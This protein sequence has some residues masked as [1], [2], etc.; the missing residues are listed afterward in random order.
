MHRLQHAFLAALT[1][2]VA[3]CNAPETADQHTEPNQT[4]TALQQSIVHGESAV[5]DLAV[6]ASWE[7]WVDGVVGTSEHPIGWASEAFWCLPNAEV[8]ALTRTPRAQ[9][10]EFLWA[11]ADQ[12]AQRNE[13]YGLGG[14]TATSEFGLDREA[15][16][17]GH[18]GSIT[19]L[20]RPLEHYQSGL[21]FDRAPVR[22]RYE[23]SEHF[24]ERM[25]G[26]AA[27]EASR[28]VTVF[29]VAGAAQT[30]SSS[31]RY[32]E[33]YPG[34][35]SSSVR[36]FLPRGR[37]SLYEFDRYAEIF[38]IRP[39]ALNV[40]DCESYGARSNR[41]FQ[42]GRWE[43]DQRSSY[44]N[45]D[46]QET[47]EHIFARASMLNARQ[48]DDALSGFSLPMPG[49]NGQRASDFVTVLGASVSGNSTN[50][51]PAFSAVAF[52]VRD[53][54]TGRKLIHIDID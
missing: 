35:E 17:S 37:L 19:T 51:N 11:W 1:L 15:A 36:T 27:V 28:R 8:V 10:L 3:C 13:F 32:N 5:P 26:Y 43:W 21:E 34:W 18:T 4:T 46:R 30:R 39:C 14:T 16:Q 49:Q 24:D 44:L 54:C 41:S 47:T 42:W 38:H 12:L 9:Q 20:A 7:T 23:P 31:Y 33:E 6:P 25:A 40:D 52:E 2:A 48:I 50:G 22:E 45:G 53:R 29:M